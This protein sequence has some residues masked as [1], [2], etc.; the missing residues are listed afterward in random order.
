M[1]PGRVGP[2]TD[3][4]GREL[5]RLGTLVVLLGIVFVTLLADPTQASTTLAP[6]Q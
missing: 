6:W 2:A 1:I 5:L 4:N 3:D